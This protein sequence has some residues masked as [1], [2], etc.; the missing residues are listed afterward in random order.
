LSSAR[1]RGRSRSPRIDARE[2][3]IDQQ[4]IDLARFLEW[5]FDRQWFGFTAETSSS[6]PPRG[7]AGGVGTLRLVS[8]A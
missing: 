2:T 6:A 4:R 8:F 7:A 5:T 1:Q 3:L